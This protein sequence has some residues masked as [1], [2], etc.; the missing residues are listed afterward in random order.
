MD[1]R[2]AFAEDWARSGFYL[3]SQIEDRALVVVDRRGTVVFPRKA[4]RG[5]E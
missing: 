3:A 2:L 5:G 1:N 4:E